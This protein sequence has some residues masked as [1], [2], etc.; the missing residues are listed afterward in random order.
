MESAEEDAARIFQE[1]LPK[2]VES[3]PAMHE[4]PTELSKSKCRN[5]NC[6]EFVPADK[7]TAKLG[8]DEVQLAFQRAF[9]DKPGQ[10]VVAV[11]CF[12]KE[13][14]KAPWLLCDLPM[15][16]Y[17]HHK[18]RKWKSSSDTCAS[19]DLLI[20]VFCSNAS[21]CSRLALFEEREHE[22]S[23]E[24]AREDEQSIQWVLEN[25]PTE[26]RSGQGERTFTLLLDAEE[27]VVRFKYCATINGTT[28]SDVRDITKRTPRILC[29]GVRSS[30]SRKRSA[31]EAGLHSTPHPKRRT[32]GS[33]VG[34]HEDDMLARVH[35]HSEA[36]PGLSP[37]PLRWL[38]VRSAQQ[39]C[40]EDNIAH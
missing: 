40:G 19:C 3:I 15:D 38:F 34:L 30:L 4:C 31:V 23:I 33:G 32:E 24:R 26:E 17:P 18:R 14:Y 2:A 1:Y 39:A 8:V 27:A 11:A 13:C 12:T 7:A 20:V 16:P 28:I 21:D 29:T 9:S 37:S 6:I 25:L 5:R 10:S 22:R 35:I 36:P